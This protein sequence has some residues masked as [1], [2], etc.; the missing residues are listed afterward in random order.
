MCEEV[1][2]AHRALLSRENPSHEDL[3]QFLAQLWKCHG[4]EVFAYSYRWTRDH[5]TA[6]EIVQQAFVQAMRFF[7]KSGVMTTERADFRRWLLTIAR[8]EHFQ[9]LRR[10]HREQPQSSMDPSHEERDLLDSMIDSGAIDPYESASTSEQIE[11]LRACLE[12]LP[13]AERK[14]IMLVYIEELPR[15]EVQQRAGWSAGNL[16]VKLHYARNRLRDCVSERVALGW[17]GRV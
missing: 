13:P 12:L 2:R 17:P 16:R 5:G 6:C 11:A 9:R 10:G 4:G 14:A 15:E 8:N 1:R 7:R 3:N